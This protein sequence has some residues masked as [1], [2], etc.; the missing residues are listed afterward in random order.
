MAVYS[1][2]PGKYVADVSFVVRRDAGGASALTSDD[3]KTMG[4]LGIDLF[5]SEYPS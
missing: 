3:M 2:V 1:V 5:L 4:P